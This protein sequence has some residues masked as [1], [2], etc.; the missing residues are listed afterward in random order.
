MKDSGKNDVFGV[1]GRPNLLDSSNV[2]VYIYA[3][4]Y[5]ICTPITSR[6]A[7]ILRRAH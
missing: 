6:A 1:L 4:H 2:C 7:N 5:F 3:Q